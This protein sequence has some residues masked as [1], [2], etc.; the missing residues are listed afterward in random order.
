[1]P[2]PNV[3][4]VSVEADIKLNQVDLEKVRKVLS[5]DLWKGAEP[6]L[7][8]VNKQIDAIGYAIKQIANAD[9][10]I[11]ADQV[12]I[13]EKQSKPF[14]NTMR[15]LAEQQQEMQEATEETARSLERQSRAQERISDL[16]TQIARK[17]TSLRR[18][19]R[20]RTIARLTE[21]RNALLEEQQ[22]I[23]KALTKEESDYAKA[24]KRIKTLRDQIATKE[25]LREQQH[26]NA[27]DQRNA[28]LEKYRKTVISGLRDESSEL[29][30]AANDF[31]REEKNKTTESVREI[32]KR[33]REAEASAKRQAK[34]AERAAKQ[35]E[36]ERERQLKKSLDEAQRIRGVPGEILRSVTGLSLNVSTEAVAIMSLA[37]VSL[38]GALGSL[39]KALWVLPAGIGAATVAMQTLKLGTMGFSDTVSALIDGDLDKFDE[40]IQKLAPN[41]QQAALALQ[42]MGPQFKE[43]QQS[44]QQALFK[45]APQMFTAVVQSYLPMLQQ[46][47]TGIAA[48]MNQVMSNVAQQLLTPETMGS[49]NTLLANTVQ[50]FKNLAPAAGPFVNAI[51]TLM[52]TGS[53]LLP[54]FGNWLVKI[55]QKFSDFVKK[56]SENGK[57]VEWIREGINTLRILGGL[58][59]AF[60]EA[61]AALAPVAEQVLPILISALT[62]IAKTIEALPFGIEAVVGAFLAWKVISGVAALTT[63]LGVVRG[64][65]AFLI[66]QAVRTGLVA[67]ASAMAAF[68]AG[69]LAKLGL[70]I[71]AAFFPI[72]A[73]AGLVAGGTWLGSK[74]AKQ[75]DGQDLSVLERLGDTKAE[76]F[77]GPGG[78]AAWDGVPIMG[79]WAT[80]ENMERYGIA[81]PSASDD[82]MLQGALKDII[83]PVNPADI[84][85]LPGSQPQSSAALTPEDS[86]AP[87]S[88]PDN[89]S[90]PLTA[91]LGPI[92]PTSPLPV[93]VTELPK[94]GPLPTGIPVDGST[95]GLTPVVPPTGAGAIDAP[96]W[97]PPWTPPSDA[98]TP[99]GNWNPLPVPPSPVDERG[100]KLPKPKEPKELTAADLI[101]QARQKVGLESAPVFD[102]FADMGGVQNQPGWPGRPDLNVNVTN[103][104]TGT[105]Y[106]MTGLPL[107]AEAGYGATAA[108]P[109]VAFNPA[110]IPDA[111]GAK[112]ALDVIGALSTAYGLQVTPQGGLYGREWETTSHHSTGNA[113]DVSNGSDSTPQ[114]RAFAEMLY[115]NYMPYIE[116]LIYNDD[117]GGFGIK[118]GQPVNA[119][120]YYGATAHRNHVHVAV[121]DAMQGPFLQAVLG[122]A[123]P[124]SMKDNIYAQNTPIMQDPTLGTYGYTQIDNEAVMRA[125]DDLISLGKEVQRL[126]SDL[127]VYNEALK[128]SI[129]GTEAH[130]DLQEKVND[131][132]AKLDEIMRPTGERAQKQ[133]RLR[134]AQTGK[135]NELDFDRGRAKEMSLDDLPFGHPTKILGNMI[136]GAGGTQADV[137]GLMGGLMGNVVGGLADGIFP[138]QMTPTAPSTPYQ[139]LIQQQNPMALAAMA[140]LNVPDFT[141]QGGGQ[142]AQNIMQGT[143]TMTANGQIM[144]NT[145]ALVD[146]TT[147]NEDQADK[148]RH[149]QVMSVLNQISKRLGS[150][151]LEPTLESGVSGGIEG[152]S[153]EVVTKIGQ[154][155]GQSAG[156][157][158]AQAVV[159]A[160]P[161]SG[162]SSGGGAIVN[163]GVGG[164][165]SAAAGVIG[166]AGF[167]SG[168]GVTGGTPGKDSVPAMLMPGEWVMTRNEVAAMGGFGGM[169]RFR[170]GLLNSGGVRYMATGGGVDVSSTVG[171]EFFGVAQVPILGAIVNLLIGVLLKV[172]GVNVEARD[173][174]NEISGEFR[175]FRGEFLA[176]EASG[177]LRND[178]SGLMDRSTS[179]AQTAADERIK[180]LRLVLDALVKYIIEKVIIPIGKAIGSALLQ[181]GEGALSAGLGAAFP[182][183]SIVGGIVGNAVTA[184]GNAAMD[185]AAEVWG[186]IGQAAFSVA[187][188]GIGELLQSYLPGMTTDLFGGVGL[189]RL[190]DPITAG[191][192]GILGGFSAVLASITDVLAGMFP[193]MKFDQGGVARGTGLMPKAT[194]KPERVLSPAQTAS[195]D[196]L[197]DA[198]TTG[199]VSTGA[200]STTTIHAPFTVTGN[201][202]GGRIVHDRLLALMS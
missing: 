45:D 155:I 167:A 153:S 119:N 106:P 46:G 2:S 198:L 39:S 192:S 36:K 152:L 111:N 24:L 118:K 175:D 48:Q 127:A 170:A 125:T 112:D 185:I 160:L 103:M 181:A 132:M 143:Q 1:M 177:R 35:A 194:V 201:E 147:T 161:K 91:G 34:D 171:A 52:A 182:G 66:P 16:D 120:S 138:Q 85:P 76:L 200:T 197:V 10:D 18:A 95:M 67:M 22:A 186:Q 168:G 64:L 102:P 136:L 68:A 42:Q 133:A 32:K 20:E 137:Q 193:G 158:I 128:N 141:R 148:A 59:W 126:Q 43:F 31:I 25:A 93:E 61:I 164:V 58:A 166:V 81:P 101:D 69:P 99:W 144:S 109:A 178:T 174:L 140:G 90:G 50:M 92:T 113:V 122:T 70:A 173:T 33:E 30:R 150:D 12:E 142:S 49:I 157:I 146:R 180:I 89:L 7:K 9:L 196:R 187:F 11:F 75:L 190:F 40:L 4:K 156:P 139:T 13:V 54:E 117:M 80:S 74:I 51:T 27:M 149:E 202:Q 56:N 14:E 184:G 17:D 159:A 21:E 165:L 73:I 114:M 191:F 199:R 57:I 78:N 5:D 115:R 86:L 3:G 65:L 60:G 176:F 110:A 162:D 82:P 38:V 131:T 44:I 53:Q 179:S 169:Q 107:P 108:A 134:E 96:G 41:A 183:G 71:K 100:N 105:G 6:R 189:A 15:K 97:L 79:D 83:V 188:Q 94:P 124:K 163:N 37:T 55:T 77:G 88:Q 135:W 129:E 123:M 84:I 87:K 130:V 98:A 23:A 104:P 62:F 121:T 26:A 72:T 154:G 19:T 151:I 47:M 172:L 8:N 63:A 195:F 145:S 28:Q 116:E 29:M